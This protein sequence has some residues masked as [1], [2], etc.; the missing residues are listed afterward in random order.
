MV[1][2]WKLLTLRW[3]IEIHRTPRGGYLG[4]RT[5]FCTIW[6][7]DPQKG[8][9]S[10]PWTHSS[11][12][13]YY[14]SFLLP[15]EIAKADTDP[16]TWTSEGTGVPVPRTRWKLHSSWGQCTVESKAL[17]SLPPL[18]SRVNHEPTHL[19]ITQ[20]PFPR[21]V[22]YRGELLP[23]DILSNSRIEFL[24][25][26]LIEAEDIPFLFDFHIPV[27]QNELSNGLETGRR[28]RDDEL[29]PPRPVWGLCLAGLG[30]AGQGSWGC[31]ALDASP[32][33]GTLCP[34]PTIPVIVN[35]TREESVGEK[36]T[37]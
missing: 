30:W 31:R 32:G 13:L 12:W 23:L 34:Q 5:M 2:R 9:V 16:W 3:L 22:A 21:A 1:P 33:P 15:R 37:R 7:Q 8:N 29:P 18:A 26:A 24:G 19:C 20:G 28:G 27:H 25:I 36:E 11:G 17:W 35:R 6:D 14:P 4:T 10:L